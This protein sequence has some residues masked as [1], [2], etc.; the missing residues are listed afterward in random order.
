[1]SRQLVRVSLVLIMLAVLATSAYR[2]FLIEQQVDADRDADRAFSALAW[3]LELSLGD[4]RAAQQAYVAAGQDRTYW[5]E[6]VSLHLADIKTGLAHLMA[7]STIH[8][9]RDGLAEAGS[10]VESLAQ[11][12]ELAREHT[13][14]GQDLMASD[15]I[16]ADGL[17]LWT[18]AAEHLELAR[19]GERDAH[20][21]LRRGQRN[22]QIVL[23]GAALG[24]SLLV[25]ILLAPAGWRAPAVRSDATTESEPVAEAQSVA[26][27][28]IPRSVD[29]SSESSLD[30]PAGRLSI[31]GPA[32]TAQ[33]VAPDLQ[34]VADLCT[35]L[36]RLTDTDELPDVL[37]RAADLLHAAGIIIW[38]R[39][40]SGKALRPAAGQGYSPDA[41]ARIGT[42][43]CDGNNATVEAYRTAQLQIVP[44]SRETLGAIVA[45]L[46]SPNGCIGVMSA[47]VGET[48]EASAA[49]QATTAIL[50]AQ[51]ATLVAADPPA[52]AERAQ[53]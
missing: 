30:A 5:V 26:D 44:S 32:P 19:I 1:M 41:L 40:E 31:D 51:L 46:L 23:L 37:R 29:D 39:D 13:A 24:T 49:V 9:S 52:Q 4:L 43:R 7:L 53:G 47:E 17:E 36:A 22:S 2:V 28:E 6:K 12:D 35:D 38:I 48:H 34:T 11:I 15:L 50:A 16:F 33:T 27:T 20:D 18:R 3:E 25:V 42:I 14:A 45:P 21:R 10:A 8:G